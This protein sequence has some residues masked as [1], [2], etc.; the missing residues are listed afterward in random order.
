MR[1]WIFFIKSTSDWY[2]MTLKQDIKKLLISR[3]LD[4]R[5]NKNYFRPNKQNRI[6]NA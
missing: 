6:S 5:A 3:D 2:N 4:L 1:K